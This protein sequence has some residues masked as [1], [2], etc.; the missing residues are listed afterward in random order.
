MIVTLEDLLIMARTI[1]GEARGESPDGRLA[2][3][4]VIRNR[5]TQH[6]RR[7]ITIAGV[8]TEPF[9]FSCWLENDPNRMKL[10]T[11]DCKDDLFRL[12]M[13]SAIQ[14]LIPGGVDIT[15]GATHYHVTNMANPPQWAI[16]HS[17]TAIIGDH[18]F[19]KGIA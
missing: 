11:I 17:P 15:H 6:H 3:G 7:E 14:A 4:W 2:V 16:G 12:C 13:M 19:F 10:L 1:W 18:S 8:C 9:Q 5:V